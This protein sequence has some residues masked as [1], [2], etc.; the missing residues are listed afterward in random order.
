M[1]KP[2][3]GE[4]SYIMPDL[5]DV[6]DSGFT[7]FSVGVFAWGPTKAGDGLLKRGPAKVRVTGLRT[8]EGYKSVRLAAASIA[9]SLDAGTY[10]GRKT[11]QAI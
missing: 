9:R 5:A 2:R 1:D 3:V 11:V 7:T 6:L 10:S 8:R 4:H